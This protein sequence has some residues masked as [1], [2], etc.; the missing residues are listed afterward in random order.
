MPC[1]PDRARHLLK[2]GKAKVVLLDGYI[3]AL[4]LTYDLPGP[5]VPGL[6]A[7]DDPGGKTRT[8]RR[9]APGTAA[10]GGSRGRGDP[11]PPGRG[12][13]AAGTAPVLPPAAPLPAPRPA[14]SVSGV[15]SLA[16]VAPPGPDLRA[17]V[18]GGGARPSRPCSRIASSP[19]MSPRPSSP[20]C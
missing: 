6:H 13:P 9:A 10:A 2:R 20:W 12:A 17:P 4:K 11:R 7:G 15:G 1:R 16:G 18:A 14:R 5:E 19:S 3:F 8:E